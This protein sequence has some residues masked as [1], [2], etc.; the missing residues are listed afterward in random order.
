MTKLEMLKNAVFGICV[1]CGIAGII[2]LFCAGAMLDGTATSGQIGATV[3]K[4]LILI[5]I[6]M[7]AMYINGRER[8]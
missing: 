3:L 6:F 4:G 1:L 5:G 8:D 7:T 2:M